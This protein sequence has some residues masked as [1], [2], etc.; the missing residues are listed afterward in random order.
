M[1]KQPCG[2]VKAERT[3]CTEIAF[4]ISVSE[5]RKLSYLKL[6]GFFVSFQK[7]YYRL[8]AV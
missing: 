2:E 5:P 8:N 3:H 4:I 7:V 6:A 1:E